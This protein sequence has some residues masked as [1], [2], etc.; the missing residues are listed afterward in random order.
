MPYRQ[1]REETTINAAPLLSRE[2]KGFIIRCIVF[3]SS[4][5][6]SSPPTPLTACRPRIPC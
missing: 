1:C 4:G 5:V 2:L 6:V 3:P